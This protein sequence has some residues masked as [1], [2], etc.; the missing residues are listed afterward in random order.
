MT[1][2]APIGRLLRSELLC[3]AR[4]SRTLVTLAVLALVP[5]AIGIGVAASGSSAAHGAQGPGPGLIAAVT[6]NGFM[7][8]IVSLAV[9]LALL[10]PLGVCVAASDALAGEAANGTLRALLLA[11]IGRLR[12][13]AVKAVGVLALAV[14]AVLVIVAVGALVGTLVVGD[15]GRLLT[16][17]GSAISPGAA[18]GRVWLAAGWTVLQLASVGAVALAV[19]A[20]TDRPLVVMATVLGGAIMFGVLTAIPALGWLHPLLLTA[21]WPALA[22]LLRD[23]VPTGALTHGALLA[24]CYLVVGIGVAV[25]GTLRREA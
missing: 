18:Y 8:P 20:L 11:P 16:L 4:R 25:A 17:S 22:D 1:S 6:A 23:P 15:G 24:L 7:L 5:L 2:T 19:S 9:A 3:L 14:V 10:L 12:L 21:A 13:V